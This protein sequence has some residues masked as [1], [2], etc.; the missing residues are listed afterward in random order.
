MLRD[1]NGG[2]QDTTERSRHR[3]GTPFQLVLAPLL[4]T[5]SPIPPRGLS[6]CSRPGLPRRPLWR[7]P[8]PRYERRSPPPSL[9]AARTG[10]CDPG[11]ELELVYRI[12]HAQRTAWAGAVER[13]EHAVARAVDFPTPEA[14]DLA[15]CT[16]MMRCEQLAPQ[17][18]SKLSRQPRRADDV[19]EHAVARTPFTSGAAR[20]RSSFG[21][22]S[23]S[24][25][26]REANLPPCSL[27]A[28]RELYPCRPGLEDR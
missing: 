27:G 26:V 13:R 5:E 23:L 15:A 28:P 18:V 12:V 17:H 24:P 16:L 21:R 7:R 2:S 11:S 25:S 14:L 3:P 19:G 22:V 10:R 1:C 6:R 9:L 20:V 4:E 8:E